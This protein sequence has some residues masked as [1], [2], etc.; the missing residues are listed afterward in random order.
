VSLRERLLSLFE[1]DLRTLAL[2]R[3]AL[4]LVVLIDLAMR[5]CNLEMFYSDFGVL[6][7]DEALKAAGAY[8]FSLYLISGESWFAGLLF[9]C[10]ALAAL[11]V[12]VGYRTRIA[13]AVCLVL[14][15]S[16]VNRNTLILIGGDNLFCCLMFWSLFLPVHA[17]WS[18]DAALS[19]VPPPA[20]NRHLSFAGAALLLQVLAVYFFSAL[21]KR[22]AE[23]HPDGTAI[24]YAMSLESYSSA[25]GRL[26][27]DYPRVLTALTWYVYLLELIAPLLAL[28]PL[29]NRPLRFAVMILLMAMHTAFIVFMHIM[30]FPLMSIASLTVLLGGWAWD[31]LDRRRLARRPANVRIYYDRDCGFCLKTVLLLKTFLVLPE[32]TVAPAQDTPRAKALLEANNSW[33]VMDV[34][35]QAYLKWP[36]FTILL[37][38]SALFWWK[39]PIVRSPRLLRPGNAAY[40]FVARHRGAFASITAVLLPQRALRFET[41]RAMQYVALLFLV[42]VAGWNLLNLMRPGLPPLA[43]GVE[44]ALMPPLQLLRIDQIWDM[45]APFPLKEDGWFVIPAHLRDGTVVDLRRPGL[46]P[47]DYDKPEDVSTRFGDLRLKTYLMHVWSRTWSGHRMLYG[48]YLCRSWNRDHDRDHQVMTFHMEYMLEMTPPPGEAAHVERQVLWR[49]ECFPEETQGNIP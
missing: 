31:A 40:D 3:V 2:F 44:R 30:P 35:D 20:A 14:Y 1:L 10:N 28:S 45:F 34:D 37:R 32:A 38:R 23:W 25:A 33:V 48:K 29:F 9:A 47:V 43:R 11:C 19:T 5:A 49:H 7:G 12:L 18:V 42:M 15:A 36:A 41:G 26:L 21:L 16:L 39:W 22:G 13:L 4:A 46:T 24:Y 27:L 17:R 8:R 6:P